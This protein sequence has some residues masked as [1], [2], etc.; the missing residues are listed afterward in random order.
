VGANK[1]PTNLINTKRKGR[2]YRGD[3]AKVKNSGK[4]A[5]RMEEVPE[6]YDPISPDEEKSGKKKGSGFSEISIL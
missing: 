6:H 4:Q 5:K 3:W 1:L 2:W